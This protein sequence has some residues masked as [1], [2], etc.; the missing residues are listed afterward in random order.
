M[1]STGIRILDRLRMRWHSLWHRGRLEQELSDELAF[2]QAQLTAQFEQQGLSPTEARRRARLELGGSAQ[3]SEEARDQRGWQVMDQLVRD[4]RMAFRSFRKHPGFTATAVVTIALGMG[5]NTSLYTVMHAML[6]RPLP[7]A[8][9]GTLRNVY[10]RLEHP[11]K[12]GSFG[13]PSYTSFAEMEAIRAGS[14]LADIAGIAE[15]EVSWRG[16]TGR[17]LRAQLVS[18]NLLPLL[19][20]RPVL[21][22]FFSRDETRE[23][24]SAPVVVLSHAFWQRQQGGDPAIVGKILT[25][26]RTP[27]TVIG[28]ADPATRGP[29]VQSAEVWIPI[30]MQRLTRPGESLIDDPTLAW[31]QL[32]A[33]ARPGA[34]DA[35]IEA[36]AT[37]L[38]ARV[39][40]ARDTAA[41]VTASVVP[42]AF[43]NT[44][45]VRR[46]VFPALG[47]I[48]LAFALILVVACANV[49]NMLL[50]RG[51]SRQREIAIRLSIGAGRRR[52][53]AQLLTESAWLGV[54]G[55]GLGLAIALGVGRLV[56]VF[57]PADLG[58]QA[59]LTPDRSV[60]AFTA[61]VSILSGIA[62][63]M[64]PAF[65]AVGRD[66]TPG[67]RTEGLLGGNPKGRL[68]QVLVGLQVAVCVVLLVNAGLLVRSFQRTLTMDA[69]KPLDHL[70]IASFDLRQQQYTPERAESFFREISE[71]LSTAPGVVAAG[72]SMLRPEL[73]S[74]DNL[75]ALG[76]SGSSG[77]RFRAAFDE[78]D[79][80]YFAA[81]GL[82]VLAGR[83][84][85]P[86]EVRSAAPVMVVDRRFADERMNGRAVGRRIWLDRPND[87]SGKTA[88]RSFEIIGVVNSTRSVGIESRELPTYYIP[89][90]GLRF[91]EG[92]LLARY[93]GPSG[94]PMARIRGAA[95]AIDPELG[96]TL[97]TIED[98]VRQAMLP[99]K[100]ISAS[101]T[102]LGGLALALASIGLFG[103]I[104]FAV[105]RR[106]REI[107]IRM[108][109]G[110]APRQVVALVSRQALT[111]VGAG[112]GAGLVLAVA[113]GHLIRGVLH[114]LSP[115]D[116]VA[117]GGVI[118]LV[119]A[120]A[121]LAFLVPAR[122]A[123]RVR[124]A[125]VLRVD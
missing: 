27:F 90:L 84:F 87:V 122:R 23:P 97:T 31:I 19:G 77:P 2:H 50:A 55:G 32:F 47:L 14:T 116:P 83:T 56:P 64:L 79:A 38:G 73:A 67:L 106:A 113:G 81:A 88:G 80:G 94:Q 26:N 85:T 36:E 28:V 92:V 16:G 52:V 30:T 96:T 44:P 5:A 112:L 15:A 46:E 74:A 89:I 49:A 118:V 4:T 119:G 39:V 8:D 120:G 45:N 101:V 108:A 43:L 86:E 12:R 107:A 104:G 34:T 1:K 58:V 40:A 93:E 102:V 72:I 60:L 95:A 100:I 65:Q 123:T 121:A 22:R 99:I 115:F 29:L 82:K 109:L 33:R 70:L 54:L 76:D 11:T 21:G 20:A 103:V 78:V 114:G 53:L 6:F 42:A 105:S 10:L 41:R 66:L 18:D 9:P 59:E 24:G 75:I 3:I 37:L 69:G 13:S 62:F 91:M 63:G 68:Q 98:N 110:A 35:A 124:P 111:P 7:V 57:L 25:L 48:W 125:T 61:I 17:P 71:R 51:V 117:I